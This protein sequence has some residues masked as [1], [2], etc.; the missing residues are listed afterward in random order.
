MSIVCALDRF[1]YTDILCSR[2]KEII[3]CI[4]NQCQ[5]EQAALVYETSSYSFSAGVVCQRRVAVG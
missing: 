4:L 5:A 2:I 1:E 3:C